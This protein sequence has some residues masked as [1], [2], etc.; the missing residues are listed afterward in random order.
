MNALKYAQF[1]TNLEKKLTGNDDV[2]E[3]EEGTT[4]INTPTFQAD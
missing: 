4:T 2:R 1:V 3:G